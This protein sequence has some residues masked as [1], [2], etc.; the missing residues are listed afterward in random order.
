MPYRRKSWREKFEAKKKPE[1][2]DDPRGRGKMLIP[3]PRLVDSLI[4]KIPRGRLVTTRILRE[5]LARDFGVDLACPLATGW[6]IKIVAECAEEELRSGKALE[7]VTPYWRVLRPDGSLNEKFPGG[8]ELQAERLR[9]EGFSIVR[10]G[11]KFK[12][13]NYREYLWTFT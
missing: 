12:V 1:I 2:V 7:E 11:R 5:K 4:R 3:T 9:S 10:K 13:E 8:V 6:F